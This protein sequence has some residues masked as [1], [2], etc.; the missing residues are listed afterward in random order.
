MNRIDPMQ[1]PLKK[2][3]SWWVI[4]PNQPNVKF[5]APAGAI[6]VCTE[7]FL[8]FNQSVAYTILNN[9]THN[10]WI[11]LACN[12]DVIEMPY[13]IFV[14]YFDAEA[15]IRGVLKDPCQLEGAKPFDYRPTLPKKPKVQLDIFKDDQ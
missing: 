11:T 8:N 15:F 9:D 14:R 13:Y 2:G 12:S 10:G 3:E 1:Y 7:S 5:H 4:H 6:T